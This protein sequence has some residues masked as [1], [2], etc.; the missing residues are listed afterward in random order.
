MS[1]VAA[2]STAP[3]INSNIM[4]DITSLAQYGLAGVCISLVLLVGFIMNRTFKFFGN[5][6]EH[7]TDAWNR[8]TEALTKMTTKLDE[9]IDAQRETAQTLRDLKEVVKT[10]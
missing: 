8:N 1:I 4:P 6:I 9:D 3:I 10:R 5:H 7:N 2:G